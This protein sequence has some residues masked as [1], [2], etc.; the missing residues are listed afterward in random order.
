M[1]G[2]VWY[3]YRLPV[4]TEIILSVPLGVKVSS[5]FHGIFVVVAWELAQKW[6]ELTLWNRMARV[7]GVPVQYR[8]GSIT[9]IERKSMLMD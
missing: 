2:G 1:V 6:R 9:L 8:R 7:V 4:G 5:M 3:R